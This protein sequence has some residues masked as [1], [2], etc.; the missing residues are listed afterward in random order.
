MTQTSTQTTETGGSGNRLRLLIVEDSA[1][2]RASAVSSLWRALG[3]QYDLSLEECGTGPEAVDRL[4]RSGIDLVFL[5]DRLP[6]LDG[7]QVLAELQRAQSTVPVVFVTGQSN[8]ETLIEAMKRGA[9]DFI[10]RD[11]FERAR[12]RQVVG[13]A[14]ERMLLARAVARSEKLAA[15]GTLAGG[16]AHE[17][18]N[19]LQVVLGH[20]QYAI[21]KQDPERWRKAL[22]YCR[23]AAE[24]GARIVRQLLTFARK[25]EALRR[26]FQ[27][28][29]AVQEAVELDRESARRDGVEVSLT[30]RR[31]AAV[32]ADRNQIVQVM[33]NLLT[34]ARHAC[35]ATVES[36]PRQERRIEIV[37]DA[38]DANARASVRDNG[39]GIH[40]DGMKRLFEPFY[41]TK[42]ALG[43]RVYDGKSHGLGLA[44][45]ATIVSEHGGRIDVQSSPGDG[46][47]F[48]LVLPRVATSGTKETCRLEEAAA[49]DPTSRVE[50][51]L[52]GKRILVVDDE[53]LI[54]ELLVGYL[55]DKGLICDYALDAEKAAELASTRRY[56]LILLDLTL[57][58]PM[59]GRELL[60]TIRA[61][62]GP[63]RETRAL[64]MTGHAPSKSDRGLFE[65]GFSGIVRKPFEMR[66]IGR[67]VAETMRA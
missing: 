21:T 55:S 14:I 49:D 26:R 37:V 38:D 53:P 61:G 8:P 31:P 15:I 50:K 43:G 54:A 29:D 32:M 39:T 9:S 30:V 56:A 42:G 46:S 60:E 11:E 65:I 18:N 3:D 22:V 17:F 66:E 1:E 5:G 19:I 57:P 33:L 6:G 40:G 63:N 62:Q 58:G 7:L 4:E 2:L 45:S 27:L 51:E 20:A 64:A 35:T 24:K 47:E 13:S 67:L 36:M 34:N 52:E 28:E 10:A 48:V 59:G 12:L 23:D 25:T 41:T 16:I 44:I